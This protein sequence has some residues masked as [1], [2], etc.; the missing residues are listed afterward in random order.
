MGKLSSSCDIRAEA[1]KIQ[2]NNELICAVGVS[3]PQ[4]K[5]DL[6]TKETKDLDKSSA[7]EQGK[8][9]EPK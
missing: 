2:E 3:A 5:A 4:K 1:Q 6:A 8:G 7:T 9:T